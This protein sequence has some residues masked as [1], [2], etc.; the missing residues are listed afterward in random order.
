M[1]TSNPRTPKSPATEPRSHASKAVKARAPSISNVA[2]PR[3]LAKPVKRTVKF[4]YDAGP[5]SNLTNVQLKGSWDTSTGR[6]AVNWDLKTVP[7][8]SLGNGRWEATV[9]LA[10]DG[11]AHEW[12]WGVTADGPSG[13]DRWAV[14]EEGN[15]Q[16]SLG[17]QT[18]EVSYSPVTYH[19]MGSHKLDGGDLGFRFWA[20]DAR[21]V[22]VKVIDR[23]GNVERFALAREADGDWF[24]RV[25][26]GWDR[27]LGKSYVY[28]VTGSDGLVTER[29]DPYA[30]DMMGEQ[31]GLGRLYLDS[32]TGKEVNRYAP[33][34]LE[35]MRFEVDDQQD[36]EAAYLVL[37]NESGRPL[38]RKEVLSRLK[39]FDASLIA[40][41]H[42]GKLNDHWSKN[43][44]ADGRIRLTPRE[45]GDAFT[46]LVN[47]PASLTG[48]RYEL[49]VWEKDAQGKLRLRDDQNTDGAYSAEERKASGINDVWSD[50]LTESSGKSFRGS[51]ITDPHFD[52]QHDADPREKDPSRWIIYQ[53]HAGSFLGVDQNGNRATLEDLTEKLDYFPK[54]GINTLELLPTNEVEGNRDW[55]YLGVN[56]LATES[57]LGFEDDDGR[58]VSGTEALK[59]F[60]DE[61][62]RQGLNVIS[63]VVYNHIHGDYSGLWN[64]D[65]KENPYFNW[66]STPG[67]YEQRDT[68]WGAV[69]AYQRE[70]V[71]QLFVD[72]AMVQVQELHFDGLRFDFTEPIKGT[73]GQAGWEL[74]REINKQV[75]FHNP[76]VWTVA[77]QFDYD[78]NMTRPVEAHGGGGGGFDAQWYTEY[79][80]R[81]VNDNAPFKPGL[82]Q[83]AA[84]GWRTDVDAFMNMMAGPRGLEGWSK[85][86]TV[87]SNHDEVGNAQRTQNTAEGNTPTDFPT[88]W[89]R[90]AARFV[91]GIG[92]LSPGIPMF[93]QGDESAAQNDFRWGNPS[94]WDSGWSW[95]SLGRGWDWD[96]LT[97]NDTRKAQYERLFNL[98]PAQRQQHAEYR[99]LSTADR[100][101]FNEIAVLPPADRTQAM[102][103]IT[104][105]Q[106]FHFFQDAIALR[107]SSPAFAANAE[108]HRVYAN[109]D[110]SVMAFTRQGGGEEFLVVSSLNHQ[111]FTGYQM[112]LP[113]GQ[114][115]EVFC[116]DAAVYGGD[117][118]GN[119]SATLN[120]GAQVP[121]N[122]PAA[123]YVVFKR[124]G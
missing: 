94:T 15:L 17:E 50:L 123:G 75:H 68:P 84:R 40:R 122:I 43:L 88:Q 53:L 18:Q 87:I 12:E 42:D 73:G 47:D 118:F 79:Q 114:W 31:R 110:D 23:Y 90:D 59:R 29:P 113:P 89:S 124:V 61:A 99:A 74:L 98:P 83:A 26:G 85:A 60:I 101:V 66:A 78:P 62:H 58:W 111:D 100:T 82:V 64:I 86:L 2:A 119:F 120:G 28:E 67:E 96:K 105:R 80:H 44:E 112:D 70:K 49:Q 71:K 39:P 4:V 20:P 81:L 36:V 45:G 34:N 106:S 46:T 48:L 109:N 1:S 10:D 77:E 54:L 41:F 63:D 121:L 52:W 21:D 116:S 107:K 65:G 13:K 27:L 108:V 16:F 69:P 91:A 95:E 117:N 19:R 11:V 22:S 25:A 97:F 102:L 76:N 57:S 38:S 92:M 7:M 5:N 32:T 115:K 103:D 55:G 3:A 72:H 35:L 14:M 33:G 30:R 56:S 9:E 104:R 93:F 24:T 37:K 8:K 6:Y 51:L